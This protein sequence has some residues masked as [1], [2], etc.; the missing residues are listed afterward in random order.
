MA[1]DILVAE[2]GIEASELVDK[3]FTVV[4]DE[5]RYRPSRFREVLGELNVV[6]ESH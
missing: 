5:D 3:L 1:I 4:G 6:L 2:A